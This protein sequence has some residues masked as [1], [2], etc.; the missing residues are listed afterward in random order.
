[1][2]NLFTATL[3]RTQ[4]LPLLSLATIGTKYTDGV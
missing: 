1:M 3:E 4:E 2:M